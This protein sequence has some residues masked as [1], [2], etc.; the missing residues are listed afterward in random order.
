M[1]LNY[2]CFIMEV[3]ICNFLSGSQI[4]ILSLLFSFCV[5]WGGFVRLLCHTCDLFS[6]GSFY[7]TKYGI[8][9]GPKKGFLYK[10]NYKVL[11]AKP[12]DKGYHRKWIP[13]RQWTDVDFTKGKQP[14]VSV[15]GA[16][17]CPSLSPSLW[18][19]SVRSASAAVLYILKEEAA[20]QGLVISGQ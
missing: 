3:W 2:I 15:P 4:A 18:P 10:N 12:Q 16:A 1:L 19:S 14:R 5:P 20:C 13:E 6:K 11:S 9:L 7:F 17:L 8:H